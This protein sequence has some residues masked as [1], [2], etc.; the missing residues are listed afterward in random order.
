MDGKNYILDASDPYTPCFMV[1]FSLLN[2]MGFVIDKKNPQLIKI[3]DPGKRNMSMINI[4]GVVGPSGNL[5]LAGSV[6]KFDYA[7]LENK[8]EYLNDKV[9]Y[10][11]KIF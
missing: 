1:P 5:K 3:T 4:Q 10:Q 8:E 9:R 11:K 2:T 6:K 7:R